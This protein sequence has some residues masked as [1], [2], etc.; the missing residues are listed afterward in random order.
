MII[1][2]QPYIEISRTIQSNG[3][4]RIESEQLLVLYRDKIIT[5]SRHFSLQDILDISYK[6]ISEETGFLYLHS[7]H[8][9]FSFYVKTSPTEFITEYKRLKAEGYTNE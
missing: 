8:Q 4:H 2:T 1:S 6:V 7:N 9:V 3:Q 5:E